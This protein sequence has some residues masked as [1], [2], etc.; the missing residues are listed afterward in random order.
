MYSSLKQIFKKELEAIKKAGLYKEERIIT[1]KQGRVVSA[2]GKKVLNFCANNYLGLAGSE[3]LIRAA[4]KGLDEHGFGLSSVRFICGTQKL[5]KTL[6]QETAAFVGKDDAIL[7]SSCMSANMG[8]FASFLGEEDVILSDALNHASIIDGIR[9]CKAERY[10]FGHLD[11]VD[12]AKGLTQMKH[13]R[14]RCIVT[15]G[16]FSMDGDVA[17]LKE[18]CALAKKHNALV[19]VDDSHSTGFMGKHG[20][21]THEHCGVQKE[22]D[23]IISTYGKTLGGAGGG[24]VAGPQEMVDL[25]RQRSRTYLFSNS[26]PPVIAYASLA[27]MRIIK[28]RP[29]LQK[30][31]WE[32][33]RYFRE[34]MGKANF[35]LPSSVH[36]IIPIMIG[37]A[38]KA[39]AMAKAM[40]KKGIYV[41]AFSY[42]VVPQG[43]ARIRVQISAAHTKQDL[44]KAIGAF[45]ESREA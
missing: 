9:L 12:L 31:L 10:L 30:K 41:V 6:E 45:I 21:G 4:K 25:L 32:N 23:V 15:D 20:R 42:P 29:T 14:V 28:K 44:D 33:V 36:P 37:D 40:L 7:Y 27:A 18:I 35:T 13:K 2:N 34:K 24:F 1:S 38:T 3:E 11:M 16:A 5:H 26:L 8:F 19:V 39:Q 43:K 22:V 17:P